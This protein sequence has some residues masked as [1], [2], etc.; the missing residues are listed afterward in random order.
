M[1][2]CHATA[3]RRSDQHDADSQAFT[4][5][6]IFSLSRASASWPESAESRKK[7]RM[8]TAVVIAL[9]QVSALGSS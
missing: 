4:M 3:G 8:K 1:I 7:G 5:R 2:P 9:N 6:M